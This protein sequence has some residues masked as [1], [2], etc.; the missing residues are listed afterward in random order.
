MR[1]PAV[2]DNKMPREGRQALL[3]RLRAK[4]RR[5]EGESAHSLAAPSW[6]SPAHS[7]TEMPP[8]L[9]G[10]PQSHLALWHPVGAET[11]GLPPFPFS[12]E[13][14]QGAGVAGGWTLGEAA[15]DSHLP[16]GC[17]DQDSLIELKPDAHGDWPATLAFAACLAAR[18]LHAGRAVSGRGPA[19]PSVLWSTTHALVAEHGRL[20]GHGLAGLGLAPDMLISAEAAREADALWALEEGLRCGALSLAVGVLKGVGLIPS[21]RLGLAAAQGRT[22]VLMLTLPASAPA[23]SAAVRLR[24]RRLPSGPHPLDHRA[25]GAP[26]VRLTLERCRRAPSAIETVSL[27]LEWCDVTYRFRLASGVG[28]RAVAARDARERARG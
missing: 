7:S 15:F 8:N 16:G 23:P 20:H 19:W 12:R 3:E 18:R 17:L 28:H 2:N 22:P 10:A 4:V 14:G 25:P 26:R 21:R 5:L 24:L 13:E 27:N 9:P 1:R 11:A 6:Q